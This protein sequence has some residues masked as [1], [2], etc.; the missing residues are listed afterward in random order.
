M[1]VAAARPSDAKLDRYAILPAL[2]KAKFG[3]VINLQVL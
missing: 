3:A 1:I 2:L